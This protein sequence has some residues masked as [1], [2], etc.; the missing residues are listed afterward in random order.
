MRGPR[1]SE[2]CCNPVVK[3]RPAGKGA[4]PPR[5]Y[6]I[7]LKTKDG[8]RSCQTGKL[9]INALKPDNLHYCTGEHL[10]GIRSIPGLVMMMPKSINSMLSHRRNGH[11]WCSWEFYEPYRGKA[12]LPYELRSVRSN[13]ICVHLQSMYS[14]M[15][16]PCS[17]FFTQRSLRIQPT[18]P[19]VI[20]HSLTTGYYGDGAYMGSGPQHGPFL[21]LG[22]QNLC[23]QLCFI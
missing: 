23:A 21:G 19:I 1:F 14:H 15:Y 5:G 3:E 4:D 20:N 17:L 10:V 16:M 11:G 2:R 12:D 9:L 8:E 22:L 18:I 7:H 13:V 6:A